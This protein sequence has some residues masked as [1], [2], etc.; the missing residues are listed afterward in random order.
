MKQEILAEANADILT[1]IGAIN[2]AR[3]EERQGATDSFHDAE[4][5][6][7][8]IFAD[9]QEKK[10]LLFFMS[11]FAKWGAGLYKKFAFERGM[12]YDELLRFDYNKIYGKGTNEA[13]N[14]G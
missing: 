14:E 7:E 4:K 6:I 8:I 10:L 1:I 2:V 5:L 9:W 11:Q 12:S 3:E 13:T